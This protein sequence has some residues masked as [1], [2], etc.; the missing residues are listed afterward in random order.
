MVKA[1]VIS[2]LSGFIIIFLGLFCFAWI[3]DSPVKKPVVRLNGADM[4]LHRGRGYPD[5]EK[6]VVTNADGKGRV[7]IIAERVLF[8]AEDMPFMAWT[9]S[10]FSPHTGVWVGWVTKQNPNKLNRIPAI[11][12]LD[13]TAVYR[14]KENPDWKGEIVALGFGFDRQMYESIVLDTV[15]IRPYSIRSMLES[16]WDELTAFEGWSLKSINVIKGG[17]DNALIR[18]A[19]LV[20]G[21]VVIAS[22]IFLLLHI[23]DVSKTGW[24]VLVVFCLTGWLLLDVLWQINLF[25]QNYLSYHLYSGKTLPEKRLV[26]PDAELYAFSNEVRQF[27]PD[28][29][30]RIF[31]T[32]KGL[33]GNIIYEQP[34]LQYFLM[35]HNVTYLENN[36]A[37]YAR[38]L[39]EYDYKYNIGGYLASG[40]YLLVAGQDDRIDYDNSTG[41]MIIGG[42]Y[43]FNVSLEFS[44][45][46]GSL[47]YI[48]QIE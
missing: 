46:N 33:R 41:K 30:T 24:N 36:F 42:K 19:P 9:F 32:G 27:L 14:M 11:L 3:Y 44:S 28:N 40:D 7:R 20:A 23:K 5:G 16:I 17:Y 26:G 34:R 35:P 21:W 6:L 43:K 31:L 48:K 15:E 18:P 1:I 25:R 2:G 4:L 37:L 8:R 22:L 38:N 29:K 13:S 45:N 12:S 10:R 47:Y 39:D